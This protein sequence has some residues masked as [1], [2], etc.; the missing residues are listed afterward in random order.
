MKKLLFILTVILTT[1]SFVSAQAPVINSFSPTTGFVGSTVTITGANFD[2]SS[3]ANNQV[4]F[5]SAQATVLTAS[6]GT[7]TVTVPAG[8]TTSL[9]SVRNAT[10]KLIGYSRNHFNGIFCYTPLEGSTYAPFN[11]GAGDQELTGINGA[12]NIDIYDMDG[13]GKSDIITGKNDGGLTIAR[14]IS[15]VG[16]MNFV[17]TNINT[18]TPSL[19]YVQ[20]FF[21]A[22]FDGNGKRDI[23]ISGAYGAFL[24]PNLSTPGTITFGARVDITTTGFYQCA[25]G[26]FDNDGKI[27]LVGGSGNSI[28]TYRNTSSGPGNFGF[29]LNTSV[30][31]GSGSNGIQCVDLDGDGKSD[32][33]GTQR[34]AD[35]IYTLRNTSSTATFTFNAPQ[36][37]STVNAGPYRLKIGDFDK[38]GKI[39]LVM[40]LYSG[41]KTCIFRNTSSIGAINFDT[42]LRL[43]ASANNYRVGVGDVNGDGFPDVVT[44]PNEMGT[45]FQVYQNTSSGAGSISFSAAITYNSSAGSEV[46]G[47]AIG[48]MDGDLVPDIATSG[49]SSNVIRF[50]RNKSSQADNQPPSAICKNITVALSPTGTATVTG[51]MID[52]GS[53]D[54]CGLA[55]FLINGASSVTYTCENIGIN[56]VT[57]T[58]SDLANNKTTCTAIVTVAPAAIIITGQTTVCQG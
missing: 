8:S 52:N 16:N 18:N 45:I 27:D 17:A 42:P 55:P 30:D 53:G 48:D 34:S 7:L 43:A 9:I 15:T 41:A 54:A 19:G 39:D 47:I 3:P 38:D 5:G 40:P 12:Y 37:F 11:T 6:F 44:K 35:R 22:D 2:G 13:D 50:H 29:V 21:V 14:N 1:G 4:F 57:L 25:A 24:F 32:I 10:T 56:N 23:V 49:I 28:I 26:D 51:A 20:Q 58:V 46:G 31:V 33:V 36:F